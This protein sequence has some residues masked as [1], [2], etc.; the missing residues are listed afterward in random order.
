MSD[1]SVQASV[2]GRAPGGLINRNQIRQIRCVLDEH[3]V[4]A[5]HLSGLDATHRECMRLA[6]IERLMGIL[7]LAYQDEAAAF[8]ALPNSKAK[9]R[10]RLANEEEESSW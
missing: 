8:E 9:Y 4:C 10:L 7:G 1:T 3:S 2:L 5:S 6:T